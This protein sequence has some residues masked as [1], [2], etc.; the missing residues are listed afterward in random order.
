MD[1]KYW[2]G[3]GFCLFAPSILFITWCLCVVAKRADEDMAKRMW[4]SEK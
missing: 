3:I 1:W 2:L 4:R